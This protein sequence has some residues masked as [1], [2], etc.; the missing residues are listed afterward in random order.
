MA[1]LTFRVHDSVASIPEAQWGALRDDAWTP[2]QEREW[3]LA[4]EE[5]GCASPERGW[6]PLHLS[7]W[8]KREL[9]ALAPAYVREDSQGEFVFDHAWAGAAER[10]RI[11]YYPKLTLSVPFTPCT[12]RR[13]FTRPGEDREALVREVFRNAFELARREGLSSVHALFL[14][15]DEASAAESEGAF[16]RLGVQFHWQNPGYRSFDDYLSRFTSRRRKNLRKEADAHLAQGIAIRT[17]RGDELSPKDAALVHRLYVSTVDKFVWGR[18]YLTPAFFE[19]VLDRFRHRLELVEATREGRVIAG[20]FNVASETHLYGR[21]WGCFEEHP[22]LHFAVCYYHSIDECIRRG[23]KV[24]EGGA[25]G[26]HK[27]SRGFVPAVT[28]SAHRVFHP[29]LERA[30]RDFAARERAAIE[31]GLAELEAEA[32]MKPWTPHERG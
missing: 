20:A 31:H 29:G 6:T 12:G 25:G 21:Y 16:S 4:L 17:R 27:L 18:R 11:R 28:R 24:F 1:D 14:T 13:V 32:D 15:D 26:E 5:T 7:L 10:A 3:M 23:V 19:R 22:F 9:V 30:T 8:R 2:F